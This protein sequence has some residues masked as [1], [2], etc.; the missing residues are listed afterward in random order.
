MK[1]I[2]PLLALILSST[3]SLGQEKK[4]LEAKRISNPPKIDGVLDDPVWESLQAYGGFNMYQPGNEGPIPQGYETEVKMAYDNKNVYVGAYMYDPDPQGILSQFSQR[5]E[6]F[7]Q[8]D[9][10]AILAIRRGCTSR[11]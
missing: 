10:F 2:L 1:F 7:V 6:I 11:D 5:D 9:H 3:C 4:T 8:A